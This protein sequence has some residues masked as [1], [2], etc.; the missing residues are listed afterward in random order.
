MRMGE[1]KCEMS[2]RYGVLGGQRESHQ[3]TEPASDVIPV[4]SKVTATGSAVTSK[5]TG[6]G[7]NNQ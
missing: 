3:N 4:A 1:C 6:Y 2:G 5:C 7:P